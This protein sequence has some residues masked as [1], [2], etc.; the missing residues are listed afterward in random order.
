MHS[1]LEDVEVS[2]VNAN[3]VVTVTMHVCCLF[4]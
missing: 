4:T 2:V 3:L 1:I